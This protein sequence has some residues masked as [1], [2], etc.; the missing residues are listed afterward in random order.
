VA[1]GCDTTFLST[2]YASGDF[3]HPRSYKTLEH[4]YR[5]TNRLLRRWT[6]L[7]RI[8]K[9]LR[10]IEYVFDMISLVRLLRRIDPDVIHLQ[11]L[12]LPM[13]DMW[14]IPRFKKIGKVVVSAHDTAHRGDSKIQFLGF[15]RCLRLFDHVIT[16]TSFSKQRVMT[17]TGLPDERVSVIPHGV[18][19]SFS[20]PVD[21]KLEAESI[22]DEGAEY[23][24]LAFGVIEHYKGIDVLITA[25]SKL[26]EALLERTRLVVA[27]SPNM[28]TAPLQE[29]AVELG[30]QDRITWDLRYIP[31]EEVNPLFARATVAAFAYREIDQSGSLH[32]AIGSG[33]PIVATA[34]GGTPEILTDGVHGFLVPPEDPDAFAQA[35]TRILDNEELANDMSAAVKRLGDDL[36]WDS[37]SRRTIDI[38]TRLCE[39]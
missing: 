24:I 2:E 1:Q 12:P 31:D 35:L 15:F 17:K 6:A 32:I 29:L 25:V 22:A 4:F 38:Y 37:V 9:P 28:D 21:G 19:N 20:D 34:V 10:A 7:E 13:V 36:S 30:I 18:F 27:G 23:V 3:N 14:F 16:L 26:P 39:N 5:R 8:R 11:T 33:N